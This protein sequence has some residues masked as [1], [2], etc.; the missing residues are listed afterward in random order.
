LIVD[1]NLDAALLLSE[2]LEGHGYKTVTAS[3]PLEALEVAK[4]HVP[5]IALVDLGLP[6]MDG[7]ELGRRL[8]VDHPKLKLV[9]LTGYGQRSD[10]ERTAAAGFTEH[11]VKP[12]KLA[13]L[14][15]L[16]ERLLRDA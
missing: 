7:F 16:L 6:V 2:A 12:I 11:L 13:V 4:N 9:A 3:H 10:R 8:L 1:D 5:T 14:T 15:A